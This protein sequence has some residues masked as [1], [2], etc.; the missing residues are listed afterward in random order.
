ML[1]VHLTGRL[2]P[3]FEDRNEGLVQSLLARHPTVGSFEMETFQL[4][5]LARLCRK[6]TVHATAASIVVRGESSP[7]SW[8]N[9]IPVRRLVKRR[10]WAAQCT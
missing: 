6:S 10:I 5:H 1:A 7:A 2:D 9:L 8:I 4:L 3:S